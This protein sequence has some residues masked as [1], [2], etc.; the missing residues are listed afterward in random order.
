ML[1]RLEDIKWKNVD[2]PDSHSSHKQFYRHRRIPILIVVNYEG[3]F[4]STRLTDCSMNSLATLAYQWL[5]LAFE[6]RSEYSFMLLLITHNIIWIK[7]FIF[8]TLCIKQRKVWTPWLSFFFSL[9]LF[10]SQKKK[11]INYYIVISYQ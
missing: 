10:N 9:F 1:K 4:S 6:K 8:Y 2:L 11:K 7:S 5:W 3:Y